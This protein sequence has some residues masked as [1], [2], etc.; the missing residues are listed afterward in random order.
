[1]VYIVFSDVHIALDKVVIFEFM[2]YA[3]RTAEAEYP[4]LPRL[5]FRFDILYRAVSPFC[6]LAVVAEIGFFGFL[7]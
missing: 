1:M 5:Q 4:F 7:R 2:L 3:S 6:P